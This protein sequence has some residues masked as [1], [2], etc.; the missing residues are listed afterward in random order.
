[1]ARW[2]SGR[3]GTGRRRGRGAAIALSVAVVLAS[4]SGSDEGTGGSSPGATAPDGAAAPSAIDATIPDGAAPLTGRPLLDVDA[5]TTVEGSDGRT[6]LADGDGRALQLRGGNIKTEEPLEDAS[7]QALDDLAGRGFDTLRLSV[8]WHLLEPEQG[9]YDEDYLAAIAEVL[10]RAEARGINVILS[11]HQDVFGPAFGFG[12]VPEWATR[13]DGATFTRQDVW[14]ANYLDPAVQN[15]WDHLYEDDDLREAQAAAWTAVAER[16]GD[17]PAVLGYDLLNEPF[18]KLREGEGLEEGASRVQSTQLT[19]MYQRL[20]DAMR[21][22]DDDGWMFVEAP[23]VASI[24][25][26]VALGPIDDDRVVFFP[27][28]YDADIETATYTEGDA[29]LDLSFFDTYEG[30]ITTYADEQGIPLLVGE[31][32]L[33][34]PERPGMG[35]F[36]DES[37]ALMDRVGS[38]WT[39]FTWCR[40]EGYC[41]IDAEGADRPNIGNI[42]RPWARAVAGTPT[43]STYDPRSMVLT[44]VFD[45]EVGDAPTELV[46]PPGLSP[47]GWQVAASADEGT[48][49]WTFD[50]ATGVVSVTSGEAVTQAVCLAPAGAAVDCTVDEP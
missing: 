24:G 16:F 39:M 6:Y 23:N 14:L 27:H 8:Y 50:E 32:G 4:C 42:V 37:L 22:V 1:M 21:A 15:A 33:A 9:T 12:G 18:G 10:D 28:M 34:A 41:P 13:T 44:V 30:L 3:A 5:M 19:S 49:S 31:W 29:E 25:L 38:G 7:D 2:G 45:A 17:H 46:V 26:P 43:S 36:V 40:G 47:D 35:A 48:W 11:F 20:I